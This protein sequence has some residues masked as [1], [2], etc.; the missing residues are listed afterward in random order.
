[1]DKVKTALRGLNPRQKAVRAR[2]VYARLNGNPDFPDPQPTLA[3]FKAAIDEL[4]A[5]N[6]EARDRGRR[7]ILHRDACAKRMDQMLTR[8]AAYVNSTAL[9]DTLKL[10]GSGFLLVKRPKPISSLHEPRKITAR[11]T[12]FP[13]QVE[14]RWEGVSGALVYEVEQAVGEFGPE[15]RWERIAITSKPQL[16]V[17]HLQSNAYHTFRVYAIGTRTFSPYSQEASGKAA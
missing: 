4:T 13:G 11:P 8:M 17:K 6:L 1:M 2:I 7:A 15:R 3:E 12:P 5:A 10:A 16:V 14:V 9:G